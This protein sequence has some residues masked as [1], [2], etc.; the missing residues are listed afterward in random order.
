ML[1]HET[2]A[3]RV[4]AIIAEV[5]RT[6]P[7][8]VTRTLRLTDDLGFD[9]LQLIQLAVALEERFG[10]SEVEETA[11]LDIVT[12]GDVEELIAKLAGDGV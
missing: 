1:S 6:D 4:H 8:T 5:G 9:S 2:I 10:I 12:V 11:M 7:G 3:E